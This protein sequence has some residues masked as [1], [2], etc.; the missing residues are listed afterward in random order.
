MAAARSAPNLQVDVTQLGTT[1]PDWPCPSAWT[2]PSGTLRHRTLTAWFRDPL[3]PGLL[4]PVIQVPSHAPARGM[5]AADGSV[6]PG[7]VW[8]GL[9]DTQSVYANKHYLP[10]PAQP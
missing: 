8:M 7:Q 4:R 6:W 10:Q 2:A 9:A 1:A 5:L 3:L